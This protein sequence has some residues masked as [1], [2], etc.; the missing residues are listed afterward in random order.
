MCWMK[1]MAFR[2]EEDEE[3]PFLWHD[4]FISNVFLSPWLRRREVK[5]MTF[6]LVQCFL[7]SFFLNAF[8]SHGREG[9]G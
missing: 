1:L 3:G 4:A 2:A 6:S 5:K 8:L 9:G 7:P